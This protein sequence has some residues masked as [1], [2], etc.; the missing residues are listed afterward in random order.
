MWVNQNG[1]VISVTVSSSFKTKGFASIILD[2]IANIPGTL[3][4]S[5]TLNFRGSGINLS[6]ATLSY[7]TGNSVLWSISLCKQDSDCNS[8]SYCW[9]SIQYSG[10][11]VS[12]DLALGF[13]ICILFGEYLFW[14]WTCATLTPHAVMPSICYCTVGSCMWREI[15]PCVSSQ[16]HDFEWSLVQMWLKAQ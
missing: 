16:L 5:S 1:W 11:L 3:S 7:G 6:G 10:S 8:N 15:L 4:S 14:I 2:N 12:F 9:N 13:G